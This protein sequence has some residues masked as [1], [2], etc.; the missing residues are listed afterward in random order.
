MWAT[1]FNNFLAGLSFLMLD[2]VRAKL[3]PEDVT[4]QNSSREIILA[5]SSKFFFKP[6]GY[7]IPFSIDF[8]LVFLIAVYY[9]Y[10]YNRIRQGI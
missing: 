9:S 5:K 2:V 7:G 8:I 6:A 4:V 3:K 10:Y 1:K